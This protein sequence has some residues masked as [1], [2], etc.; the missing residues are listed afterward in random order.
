MYATMM[1]LSFNL[2]M[3]NHQ[4]LHSVILSTY[5]DFSIETYDMSQV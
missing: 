1:P 4:S 2:T 5:Y 3:M